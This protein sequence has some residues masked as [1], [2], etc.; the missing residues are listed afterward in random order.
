MASPIR[1]CVFDA[2]G[3]LFDV[4]SAVARHANAVGPKAE[5]MSKLWR[6]K[7]LEYT[8]TR[9]LM[10]R[11]ADFWAVTGEAL[12]VALAAFGLTGAALRDSLLDAYRRLAAY[13]EVPAVLTR[14][15][16]AGLK[17]AI[18]SNG[19]PAMLQDAVQAAGIAAL[20]D[21]VLSVEEIGIYKPA[22]RV[23]QIACRHFGVAPG[24]I[25]FQSSNAWDAAGAAAYG[26]R[27]A[28]INR[29]GQ[30]DEYGF[31]RPAITLPSLAKLPDYVLGGQVLGG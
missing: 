14:L 9:T 19:T 7:Q 11:H 28:W 16:G 26:F 6:A 25:C 8:W 12:D 20:L 4:H 13:P 24:E 21:A 15:R 29:G 23:Y 1:A 30:P 10:G 27:V 5:E 3:T 18:L 17:T 22:A 31:A 2:Y